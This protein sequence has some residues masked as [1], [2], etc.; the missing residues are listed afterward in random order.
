MGY[1][2]AITLILFF[3]VLSGF[4]DGGNL[5]ATFLN[6]RTMN[7]VVVVAMTLLM[8]LSGPFLMGTEVARTIGT[9]IVDIQQ[10]GIAT[11]NVALVGTLATLL[12]CWRM[13]V[14]TSTSFA[15]IGGLSGSGVA[16]F[17]PDVVV[18]SGLA[19]VAVSLIMAVLF[20]GLMGFAVYSV[21]LVVLRRTPFRFGVRLGYAQYISSALVSFGYGANDAEKSVGLLATVWM[22]L[23]GG[24]FRV[25]WWMIVAPA[26]AFG[27]GLLWGGWRVAKTIGFHVFR[28]R[29]VHSFA[30]QLSTAMVV[31][32][33]SGLG[34][35]VS[36]TQTIDSA[37][38][39]VGTRAG[40]EKLRWSVV[41]RMAMVW[42][43]TMPMAFGMSAAIGLVARGVG[44]L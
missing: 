30:T 33:A 20:G 13:K 32:T 28:A 15:L 18:W 34:G 7:V 16:L 10:V 1:T 12:V 27:G 2:T 35:P 4:N 22:L 31:L 37:L 9:Q 25:A 19:K 43:I 3:S 11:L 14:P 8:V 44:W 36:T 29:P 38:V 41:R 21:I 17:G 24:S 42:F 5:L 40:K 26:L 39:G 23:H 6:T